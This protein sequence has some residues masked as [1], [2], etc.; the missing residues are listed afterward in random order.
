MEI[1]K[2]FCFNQ[3]T[4]AFP[5]CDCPQ[6]NRMKPTSST[7]KDFVTSDSKTSE[8][9]CVAQV[10]SSS[11]VE[12]GEEAF[13]EIDIW[14]HSHYE[15]KKLLEIE[16]F[17]IT[18]IYN[19]RIDAG[20]F[21]KIIRDLNDNQHL[22]E[23]LSLENSCLVDV[24]LEYEA[25]EPYFTFGNIRLQPNTYQEVQEYD[26]TE[27]QSKDESPLPNFPK[28]SESFASY[29]K[30]MIANSLETKPAETD[31]DWK[32]N[33]N[34]WRNIVKRKL[35]EG[36]SIDEAFAWLENEVV[37]PLKHINSHYESRL[38]SLQQ[39]NEELRKE[40]NQ[41]NETIAFLVKEINGKDAELH[42]L[43]ADNGQR[44]VHILTNTRNGH[45]KGVFDSNEAAGEFADNDDN[46]GLPLG[47]TVYE[48]QSGR[49]KQSL[50]K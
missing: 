28:Q 14:L 46:K 2:D 49:N 42:R 16:L 50:N 44:A 47:I 31:S 10:D 22:F 8:V 9:P 45:I 36:E 23:A 27:A 43:Q 35:A 38:L 37:W 30:R 6:H 21:E 11:S 29:G 12:Q 4:C 48:V 7:E 32:D 25:D 5:D 15:T 24:M 3:P 17:G 33:A 1:D 18:K 20:W 13:C 34:H 39:E 40:T 26:A 41:D 19:G